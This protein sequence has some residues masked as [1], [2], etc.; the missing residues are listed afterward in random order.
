VPAGVTLCDA[1]G[2]HDIPV[3]EWV[4]ATI[5]AMQKDLPRY[6]RQ[7]ANSTWEAGSAPASEVHGMEVLILGHGSIGR[8]TARRLAPLGARVTGVALHAREDARGIDE[9]DTLLPAADAVVVLLPL[10]D[11]TRG[12]VDAGFIGRMKPN[13]LLVN[14]GRGPVADT[15]AI[16]EAVRQG[17]IRVALDVVDP[18]PLPADHPLWQQPGALLTPHVAG[19]SNAFLGRAWRFVGEQVRRYLDGAPLQNVVREDY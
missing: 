19:S 4:V 15:A 13:A 5:L 1:R 8:A 2:V 9:L 3:S 18:E 17:R 14:A 6:V 16:T 7:Q 10:T 12:M 11:A